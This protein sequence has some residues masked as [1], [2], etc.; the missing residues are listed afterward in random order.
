MGVAVDDVDDEEQAEPDIG[1]AGSLIPC[2]DWTDIANRG[3]FSRCVLWVT[4][5]YQYEIEQRIRR[6]GYILLA[7][8]AER[9][10]ICERREEA[11][12]QLADLTAKL[13]TRKQKLKNA[14]SSYKR[15]EA[16]LLLT[17][18]GKY[19]E[20]KK[21]IARVGRR[22]EE[23]KQTDILTQRA[24]ED[25]HDVMDTYSSITGKLREF[26]Q[27]RRIND[28]VRDSVIGSTQQLLHATE[29]SYAEASQNQS[30]LKDYDESLNNIRSKVLLDDKR[31]QTPQFASEIKRLDDEL[32][33]DLT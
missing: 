12:K 16:A 27:Q 9:D 8:E 21:L 22:I 14:L 15:E 29:Q 23:L 5:I 2:Y 19:Y 33:S 6:D 10:A 18:K 32:L 28:L 26:L 24:L 30:R 1:E 20:E 3:L 4:D 31:F 7:L 17:S 13:N 25:L 11:L